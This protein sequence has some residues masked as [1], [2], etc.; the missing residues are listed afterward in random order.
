MPGEREAYWLVTPSMAKAEVRQPWRFGRDAE[1]GST[2]EKEE[3]TFTQMMPTYVAV[4][5]LMGML[6]STG[7]FF[8]KRAADR[9]LSKTSGVVTELTR[10]IDS[11]E[12][13]DEENESKIPTY[14]PKV[15]F[16]TSLGET[17]EF[18]S[19][20]YS[21]RAPAIGSKVT[22][23]YDPNDL[24]DATIDTFANKFG[25][26]ICI[27]CAGLIVLS[28]YVFQQLALKN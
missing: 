12:D 19:T 26:E 13:S 20:V 18:T 3:N 9:R 15:S 16:Q 10:H 24:K 8:L 22:V 5:G 25:F 4:I 17:V 27:F 21:S 2:I 23:L 1:I 28:I 6:F 7:T 14:A 11:D